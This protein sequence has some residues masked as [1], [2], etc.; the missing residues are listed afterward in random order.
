MVSRYHTNFV[1]A[2]R[3]NKL[4][5]GQDLKIKIDD[6]PLYVLGRLFVITSWFRKKLI[7]IEQSGSPRN[8][9]SN[10]LTFETK[11]YTKGHLENFPPGKYRVSCYGYFPGLGGKRWGDNFEIV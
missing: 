9:K 7:Q 4:P 2:G 3:G 1:K 11:R 6:K 8:P 10:Q 5:V